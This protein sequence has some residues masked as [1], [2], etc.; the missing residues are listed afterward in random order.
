MIERIF[1]PLILRH[2]LECVFGIGLLHRHFKL[3]GGE[4]LIEFDDKLALPVELGDV[5]DEFPGGKILPSGWAVVDGKLEPYE[6]YFEPLAGK[7]LDYNRV[8]AF[9]TE[10][11]EIVKAMGLE[12]T[13]C[14]R[15]FPGEGYVG[16][17]EITI[18]RTNWNLSPDEV[19]YR[20]FLSP[21]TQAVHSLSLKV[22]EGGW[23]GATETMW[24]FDPRWIKE[25]RACFCQDMRGNTHLHGG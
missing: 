19:C 4:K 1:K 7:E 16:G 13:L 6:F 12:K 21:L 5:E 17:L 20:W 23:E 15:L 11:L 8:G 10:Y 3:Y 2:K 14:L 24:F 25:K 18:G 9:L 22:P